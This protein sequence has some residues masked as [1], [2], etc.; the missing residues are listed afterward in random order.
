MQFPDISKYLPSGSWAVVGA[1]ATRL[2]MPERATNDIDILIRAEDS[3][4]VREHLERM[5]AV[6]QSKL[7]I[8]GSSWIL[9]DGFPLDVIEGQET[10][11]SQAIAEAQKNRGAE[12]FPILPMPY[13]ILMKFQA[14]RVQDIADI[15]RMLGQATENQL[16][17]VRTVFT[18]WLP[19]EAEDLE[20]L[21]LLGQMETE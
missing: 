20:S 19:S 12:G 13:L 11:V 14:S 9:P 21:I 7:S 1:A 5:G 15:S 2:Y 17:E 4:M 3:A 16:N 18:T 10:W 6:Y 8:G